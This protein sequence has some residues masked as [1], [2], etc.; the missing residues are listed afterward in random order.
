M[1]E[2]IDHVI[3]PAAGEELLAIGRPDQTSERPG[4]RDPAE[5]LPVR[6]IHRDDLMLAIA[7]VEDRQDRPT[8]MERDLHREVSQPR[9]TP[10]RLERPAV[11]QQD[12][13]LAGH[14]RPGD[15][16]LAHHS[17]RSGPGLIALDG[18]M[19]G[20]AL[21]LG[22][23]LLRGHLPGIGRPCLR[24]PCQH[25]HDPPD[26]PRHESSPSVRTVLTFQPAPSFV[27]L[28]SLIYMTHQSNGRVDSRPP[29]GQS[30]RILRP[31]GPLLVT[32]VRLGYHCDVSMHAWETMVNLR[33]DIAET[34]S[35]RPTIP[36]WIGGTN[37]GERQPN[38]AKKIKT[39]STPPTFTL[40]HTLRGTRRDITSVAWSPDGLTL[41]SASFD[42]TVRLWEASSGRAIRTLQRH[43][44]PSAAWRSRQTDSQSPQR[45]STG[46]CG[47][48]RH[49]AAGR[50]EPSKATPTVSL[51][52][53]GRQTDSQ[54]PRRP[55]IRRCGCGRH[56]A[57][58]RSEPS[59][60][61]LGLY[62]ACRGRQTDSQLPRRPE[63]TRCG[64]GRHRAAERSG[65]W[66]TTLVMSIACHGR[67]TDSAS[68]RRPTTKRCGCGRHLVVGRSALWREH[69]DP[70]TSVAWSPD[71]RVLASASS[72]QTVRLWLRESWQTVT[73]L[74]WAG[75]GLGYPA[76]NPRSPTIVTIDRSLRDGN[77]IQI[78]DYDPK[79][80]IGRTARR[81]PYTT[82]RRRSC[83][84]AT[85]ASAKRGLGGGWH[86]TSSK[87]IPRRMA[88]SSGCWM[89]GS[90]DD[91]T[92]L[93]AKRCYGTLPVSRTTG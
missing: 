57:A 12:G 41:A 70:V 23:R 2:P 14:A 18:R 16:L 15:A 93:I 40:R 39:D 92:G 80:L 9:L 56:R 69:S 10:G 91:R 55:E 6:P 34:E 19:L 8:R 45:P 71:G 30:P 50:S 87:N 84:S 3:E 20:R 11:G 29:P 13:P 65:P 51:E 24:C 85:R 25:T 48:G 53:R 47:C 76:F 44:D 4:Q 21:A 83:W 59:R 5:H 42:R 66:R 49:R 82:S 33:R 7:G 72:D 54:L 37:R 61:T 78:W 86:M 32:R 38:H 17:R 35:R 79:T 73:G 89:S 77:K 26:S 27:R 60:A 63:T 52:C 31:A 1:V 46:Q 22:R 43:S 68:H 75:N 64:C 36:P 58:G 74:P 67:L 90:I 88:S 62:S 28:E 81:V